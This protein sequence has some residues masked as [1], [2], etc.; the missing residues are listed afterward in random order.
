MFYGYEDIRMVCT[1][2]EEMTDLSRWVTRESTESG[3][4]GCQGS[5]EIMAIAVNSA[6]TIA[7]AIASA[8]IMAID[9]HRGFENW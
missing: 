9:P 6:P 5:G 8:I 2:D 4:F 1:W 3:D 7:I